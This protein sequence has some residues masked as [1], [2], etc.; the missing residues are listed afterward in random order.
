MKIHAAGGY[1]L[2]DDA[3]DPWDAPKPEQKVR[4]LE[5]LLGRALARPV[6]QVVAPT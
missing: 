5:N 3:L 2:V 6:P 1:P 4:L